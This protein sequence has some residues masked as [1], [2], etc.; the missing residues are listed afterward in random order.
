MTPREY[1][2]QEVDAMYDDMERRDR[3]RERGFC[4]HLFAEDDPPQEYFRPK[5]SVLPHRETFVVNIR[6][7]GELKRL[8]VLA[9]D[10]DDADFCALAYFRGGGLAYVC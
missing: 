3:D 5:E 4:P 6:Q 9:K 1:R 7:N 10:K 2:Q 8:P